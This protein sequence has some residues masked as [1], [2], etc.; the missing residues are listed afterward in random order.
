MIFEIITWAFAAFTLLAD[1]AAFDKPR[2]VVVGCGVSGL[3]LSK[4]YPSFDSHCVF[5]ETFGC[6]WQV[7]CHW[8]GGA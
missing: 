6:F 5:S 8:I 3:E 4:F 1:C 7:Q 2:I